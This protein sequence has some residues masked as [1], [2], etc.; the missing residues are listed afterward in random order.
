MK[1]IKRILAGGKSSR[2][3]GKVKSWIPYNGVPLIQHVINRIAPQTDHIIIS[4]NRD[5]EKYSAFG[6]PVIHDDDNKIQG[7]LAGILSVMNFVT[8]QYSKA[9]DTNLLIVPCDM[10]LIPTNLIQ[11]LDHCQNSK[12]IC[13]A[14]DAQRIQPLVAL[15]PIAFR[16]HLKGFLEKGY[17]KAEQWILETEPNIIDL[18]NYNNC[19]CNINTL[20][21]LDLL[22]TMK[23]E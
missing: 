10:P 4:A 11:L 8:N 23:I 19:F 17:R 12:Q 14:K 15:V 2:F 5:L 13:V 1:T 21:E 3:S 7:P 20:D 22:Q 6:Y 18:S 16:D 9:N